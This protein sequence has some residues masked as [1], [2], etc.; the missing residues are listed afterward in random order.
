MKMAVMNTPLAMK[1][2]PVAPMADRLVR[3]PTTACH[4]LLPLGLGAS[5][6]T[7][8]APLPFSQVHGPPQQQ[9]RGPSEAPAAGKVP[10]SLTD[11]HLPCRT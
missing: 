3:M 1:V 10:C 5:P 4:W 6:R 8:T 11:L 2:L 7:H 9:N